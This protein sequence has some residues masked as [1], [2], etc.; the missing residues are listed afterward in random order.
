MTVDFYK[1]HKIME[2]NKIIQ[3]NQEGDDKQKPHDAAEARRRAR[4]KRILENSN[5]R[6]EKI[7]GRQHNEEIPVKISKFSEYFHS[8]VRVDK[9][10]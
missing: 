6:L 4:R 10:L 8:T 9:C 7:T 5:N 3:E 2:E 1:I